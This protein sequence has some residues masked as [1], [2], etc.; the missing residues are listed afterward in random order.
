MPFVWNIYAEYLVM[1]TL[2]S[3]Y[4]L[5]SNR[6]VGRDTIYIWNVHGREG[7]RTVIGNRWC[8]LLSQ[9]NVVSG[10]LH[11][12]RM[13]VQGAW[14]WTAIAGRVGRSLLVSSF[15]TFLT[16]GCI[17]IIIIIIIIHSYSYFVRFWSQIVA[18]YFLQFINVWI[19]AVPHWMW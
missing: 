12:K 4:D 17:I 5:R 11:F 16:N 13:C 2:Q 3:T 8:S 18:F 6:T 7:A 19:S 9:F 10:I 14:L 1:S 15:T